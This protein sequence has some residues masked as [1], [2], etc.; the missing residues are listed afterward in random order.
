MTLRQGS[1]DCSRLPIMSDTEWVAM[2]QR[3]FGRRWTNFR[4]AF[5]MLR[6]R[7]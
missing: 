2:L 1:R 5:N 4:A 3:I 7:P 6:A